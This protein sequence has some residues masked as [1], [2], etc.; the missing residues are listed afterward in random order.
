MKK[1]CLLAVCLC[2][3]IVGAIGCGKKGGSRSGLVPAAGTLTYKGELVDD[4][5][6][7]FRPATETQEHCVGVGRTDEKGQF[8]VM[9]DRPNDG[10]L[11]GKYK[12]TV[13]KQ[14]QTIDGKPRAEYEAELAKENGGEIFFDK[15]KLVVEDLTPAKYTD[16][17]NTP[18]E[19]E[20][21]AKGDKKIEIVLE[22]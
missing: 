11:P 15:N 12:V 4:A 7:E 21:P 14:V 16:P 13:K 6:L 20:I 10:L 22:D 8:S 5:V 9:T 1:I 18:L 17:E 19:V 2:V 3:L